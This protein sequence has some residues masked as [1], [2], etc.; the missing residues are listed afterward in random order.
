MSLAYLLQKIHIAV[1]YLSEY[2]KRNT[3]EGF[4]Y[5]VL[6][7]RL[8]IAAGRALNTAAPMQQIAAERGFTKSS[9]L[10]RMLKKHYG[11]SRSVLRKNGH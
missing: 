4:Q 6:Q 8:R 3:G 2:F 7:S 10:N 11:K 9:D 1:T 5:F